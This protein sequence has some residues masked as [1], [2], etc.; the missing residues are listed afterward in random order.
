MP[1]NRRIRDLRLETFAPV[2]PDATL[3][4]E[5]DEGARRF[6]LLIELDRTARPTKN[7]DK[8]RRYDALLTAWWRGAERYRG[9]EEPPAVVFVC[10]DEQH[11]MNLMRAADDEVTG[12]HS[13]FDGH[14]EG[15]PSPGRQRMLFAAERAVHQEHLRAWMLPPHPQA[16][17]ESR[18][19]WAREVT[20]PGTPLYE[21]LPF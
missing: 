8:L 17:D 11:V 7:V 18:N 20:L 16:E 3:M 19:F 6:E 4:L 10:A 1:G 9:A 14:P 2:I 13:K 21:P 15:W 12:R 5:L